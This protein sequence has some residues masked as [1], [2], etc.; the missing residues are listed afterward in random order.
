MIEKKLVLIDG[1]GFVFRAYHSLPPLTRSDGTPVGA[2]YGFTNMLIKL[3]ATL[4]ASHV[5]VVFDSGS[6]TFRNDIYPA[7]KANR[8]PCPEDLIPQFSIVREAAESLNLAILEKVG[9]EADDIIATLAKKY[10]E[11]NF[12]VLIISSDKDLMQLVSPYI[13][14][15]DAMKNK[16]IGAFEVKE[17]FDVLPERVLDV[18]SL[19]GDSSDNIPGVKGIGPK[20]AAE[21]I[22]HFGNLENIFEHLDEIKQEKRRQL[23]TDGVEKAK[24]SKILLTLKEDVEMGIT[25]QD[26]EVRD[27]D[28]GKLA[29]FLEKQGFR[30]LVERVKKEFSVAGNSVPQS[31]STINNS[32]AD[33][34]TNKIDTQKS[35]Y[36]A[37]ENFDDIKKI[38]ID[39]AEIFAQIKKQA[40]ENGVVTIDYESNNDEIT[41]LTLSSSK[42]EEAIKEIYYCEIKNAATNGAIDLFNFD[43]QKTSNAISLD[44]LQEILSD[45]SIKKIFFDAKNFMRAFFFARPQT[46]DLQAF[47][48][49]SLINHLLNSSIKNDF[50]ELISL[51]L[52]EDIESRDFTAIFNE[53]EKSKIPQQFSD[54]NKK[55]EFY[56]FKN[57]ALW[58]LYKILSPKIISEKL[59]SSYQ[60]CEKPLLPILASIENNGVKVDTKKLHEL[61]QEFGDRILSL[62]HQIHK[63][64]GQEFNI[65][66][67][68][69]LGE[70][71]FEKMQLASSKKSKKTGVLSTNSEVL[72][73]LA[74]QGFEIADK[75]LE[76]RKLSKLKNTYT[77]ALPKEINAKTGRIH[78]H[79]SSISTITG[80]LSS[81]NPNLQNIP[82][83]SDEGKK[84]RQS[85]I[86]E[87]NHSLI[88][89]DYSQI[90]LRVIAH[91][92]QIENL[93]TAF[94]EDKDIHRITA[95]QVFGLKEE[96]VT[97]AI[98]S[99]AK[100]IN[101]GIIYGISGFGL[102]RQLGIGRKEAGEYIKSY[103][104]TY[105]GID[106]Y[107]K[108]YIEL[109][110]QNGFVETIGGRKCFIRGINDKHPV[111]RAESERLAINAP[112]QGSAADIIKK[113][114]IKLDKKMKEKKLVAKIILQIHDELL[115]EAPE[116]EV[117]IVSRLIK[118]EMERAMALD[119]PLKVD[120]VVGKSWK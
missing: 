16:M 113:A 20:T 15:Y 75:V 107:M 97:A 17:K 29:L 2:V 54:E 49:I 69:Q 82:I 78:T 39:S 89:V 24:L 35:S 68:K 47:E 116:N 88:S 85:F 6:K 55:V 101:F 95:A 61:S 79:L 86:A 33:N 81:S 36:I 59:T 12:K 52:V 8:P 111:I 105:P 117:D 102:A 109:A 64:A 50:R 110:R 99:K 118:E 100:A 62:S 56:A 103:L 4:H 31:S 37:A 26:L 19:M 44:N 76:F 34:H 63:I 28:G 38:I 13:K 80:R 21:L 120:V 66:S 106:A 94:K 77:D 41:T 7:Y 53:L 83:K 58:Q 30:S 43:T 60:S 5:A 87:K 32:T 23:L 84:I 119:V 91:I 9:V 74:E 10:A 48:D 67:P 73:E 114:M 1:Y 96:D 71:L 42:H 45:N 98:R 92:A 51:N 65:A 27:I 25:L 90:E 18:L 70:I 115:I 22:N 14:M 57:Y 40:R 72:E 11:E 112:I 93:I 46:F 104:A 3:L 108:K